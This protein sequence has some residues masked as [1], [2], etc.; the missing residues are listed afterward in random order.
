M[1]VIP[2]ESPSPHRRTMTIGIIIITI[3]TTHVKKRHKHIHCQTLT[4]FSILCL[5]AF[6]FINIKN[7]AKCIWNLGPTARRSIMRNQPS[8]FYKTVTYFLFCYSIKYLLTARPLIST[9]LISA[10]RYN[11]FLAVC[12]ARRPS[13]VPC[14]RTRQTCTLSSSSLSS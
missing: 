12:T 7:V 13:L 6:F 5:T 1:F 11:V 8:S 2:C 10:P 3:I 4:L 14:R 9:I